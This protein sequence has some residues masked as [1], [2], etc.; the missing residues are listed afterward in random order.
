MKQL[1]F[2]SSL[3]FYVKHKYAQETTETPYRSVRNGLE[4][5]ERCCNFM[6]ITNSEKAAKSRKKNLKA[7]KRLKS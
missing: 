4:A 3:L 1:V 2:T 6:R 7:E 5:A